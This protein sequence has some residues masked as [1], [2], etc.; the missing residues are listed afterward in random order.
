[1]ARTRTRTAREVIDQ[2]IQENQF[3]ERLLYGFA[4]TFVISGLAMLGWSMWNHD[5]VIAICGG[6]SSALFLPAMQLA[7]KTRRENIAIRLLEAPL[8]RVDTA[9]AA[10]EMLHGLFAE[11]FRDGQ[12][13]T[14]STDIVVAQRAPGENAQ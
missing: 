1:M 2:A 13:S 11:I 8:S 9:K 12:L 7:R 10:S 6:I 14:P 3:G 4:T 5:G